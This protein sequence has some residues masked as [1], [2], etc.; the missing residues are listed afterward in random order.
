MRLTVTTFLSLDGV[1]QGPG[2]P[3]EDRSGGF[4][5]G[6]W[7]VPYADE[8]RAASISPAAMSLS[9]MLFYFG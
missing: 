2:A 1:M 9:G 7:L 6:G 4:E 5:Q 8:D 3:N